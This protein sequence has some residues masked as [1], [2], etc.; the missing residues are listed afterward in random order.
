[1]K[2]CTSCKTEKAF[3]EFNKN[4]AKPDGL[5]AK[6]KDCNKEYLKEHYQKNK[7]YYSDKR[8]RNRDVYRKEF[9][10]FLLTKSCQSC[11]VSDIRVLE[12]DHRSDKSFNI[13]SKMANM[14]LKALMLEI[15]KCDILCANCHRIK[16]S[17]QLGWFKDLL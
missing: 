2:F 11:G 12:F 9:Y 16:T 13:S 10:E 17:K 6:C 8:E 14:P 15:E 5:S 1:M 7:E 4:R 3:E